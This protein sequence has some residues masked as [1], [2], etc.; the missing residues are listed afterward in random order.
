MLKSAVE[1]DAVGNK[2][3]TPQQIA[4]SGTEH[5]L[6]CAVFQ[7]MVIYGTRLVAHPHMLF[8]IPNGGGR[9]P[10]V[11][12]SMRAE[13]V[14]RGVPDM[15]YPVPVGHW[16]GLWLEM[17]TPA[18]FKKKDNGRQP[19]QVQWHGWLR[20]HGFAVVICDGW[21]QACA[22]LVMY[23]GGWLEMEGEDALPVDEGRLQQ[24][25]WPGVEAV[26]LSPR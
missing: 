1:P 23:E 12:A 2:M 14:K 15:C 17:K 13:G 4:A 19:E 7:A 26:C 5:A 24:W 21:E 18:A 3:L 20:A 22:A 10:S 9:T 6:Q 8:A 11:A 25:Q 16:R